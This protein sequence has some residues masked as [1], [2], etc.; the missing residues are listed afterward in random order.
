METAG[1]TQVA[2]ISISAAL[3]G[4]LQVLSIPKRKWQNPQTSDARRLWIARFTAS[5]LI[6][7]R[8]VKSL[9]LTCLCGVLVK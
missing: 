9:A 7:Q 4:L 8:Q 2:V 3:S 5:P 6:V 1:E